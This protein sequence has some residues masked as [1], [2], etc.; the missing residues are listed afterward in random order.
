VRATVLAQGTQG[1]VTTDARADEEKS[2]AASLT[3]TATAQAPSSMPTG[4]NG[5]AASS[6]AGGLRAKADASLFDPG[7]FVGATATA[8]HTRTFDVSGGSGPPP[9][10]FDVNLLLAVDGTLTLRST[11]NATTPLE[12]GASVAFDVFVTDGSGNPLATFQRLANLRGFDDLFIPPIYST[13][14]WAGSFGPDSD[15]DPL[16]LTRPTSYTELTTRTISLGTLPRIAVEMRLTAEAHTTPALPAWLAIS[17]FF[18]T[19]SVQVSSPD[20]AVVLTE[21]D[22]ALSTTT[23][24]L[25]GRASLT[26]D[27]VRTKSRGRGTIRAH[28]T[29]ADP[30]TRKGA[31]CELEGLADGTV[32]VTKRIRHRFN[33]RGIAKAVLKLNREGRQRLLAGGTLTVSV[34]AAVTER[35][36]STTS[37]QAVALL[38]AAQRADGAN[39]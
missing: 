7:E 38:G 30:S 33:K 5:Q 23:T 26:I 4:A 14:T 16:T 29:L 15:P 32:T 22:P 34:V 17:N 13:P 28:C 12:I 24:T 8:R 21:V 2:P 37:L 18:D 19:A 25:P 27:E 20:P 1:G 6:L 9:S 3:D 35:D 31:K 39:R 36:G 11:I 10:T